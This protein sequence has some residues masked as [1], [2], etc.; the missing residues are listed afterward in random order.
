MHRFFLPL[1]SFQNEEVIFPET[2]S[3]QIAQV[4][5]L[6]PESEVMVLDGLGKEHRVQLLEVTSKQTIGKVISSQNSG[7]EPKTQ[8]RLLLCVA[9]R[10]KFE[11]MLQKCTEIGAS[12]FVPV[13]SSRSLVQSLNE[14]ESKHERWQKIIKEAAEQSHRGKIPQLEPAIKLSQL[15]S[16]TSSQDTCRLIPWEDEKSTSIKNALN[17]NKGKSIEI[18]IGPE[19]GFSSA[20]VEQAQKAAFL[21][22]S[23]GP[24]ILRMETA[25]MAAT[26]LVLY[27]CGDMD[28][29]SDQAA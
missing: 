11:W 8:V 26:A 10:E 16:N 3:R 2:T 15:V 20:E 4:L 22:V 12:S 17:K 5:R 13:V 19:G 14:I 29:R 9:Q 27:E 7:G 23:L 1:S 28:V 25:A 18:L 6:K 21:S 24:R